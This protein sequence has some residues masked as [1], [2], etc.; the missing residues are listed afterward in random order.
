M[1]V[2][3]FVGFGNVPT[4]IAVY[5]PVPGTTYKSTCK[6]GAPGLSSGAG[7]ARLGEDADE[8]R[9]VLASRRGVGSRQS[10]SG[11][12]LPAL[13]PHALV[14]PRSCYCKLA[15]RVRSSRCCIPAPTGSNSHNF[16]ARLSTCKSRNRVGWRLHSLL[17]H[18]LPFRP[19]FVFLNTFC[20][21]SG[22]PVCSSILEQGRG[23]STVL[24][25]S[26]GWDRRQR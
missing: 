7:G 2:V 22:V 26:N 15:P 13:T 12:S 21:Q 19:K 23:V 17:D 20:S 9:G 16:R 3:I 8:L 11:S 4:E 10:V 18:T 1:C 25:R 14:T 6:Q 24:S 5:R